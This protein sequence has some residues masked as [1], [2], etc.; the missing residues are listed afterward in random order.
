VITASDRTT[1]I[2]MWMANPNDVVLAGDSNAAEF[3]FTDYTLA[4]G[5]VLQMAN[6]GLQGN[7]AAGVAS[8]LPQFLAEMASPPKVLIY[9]CPVTNDRLIAERPYPVSD[10]QWQ[11]AAFTCLNALM[12]QYPDLKLLLETC[13]LPTRAAAGEIDG[14][15]VVSLNTQIRLNMAPQL[16]SA[17]PNRVWLCDTGTFCQ[18]P[19]DPG[20]AY[21]PNM[22]ADGEHAGWGFHT[23][24]RTW[25][26]YYLNQM[27]L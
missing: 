24:R 2:S 6:A 15:A 7:D 12:Q 13:Y 8:F 19:N 3:P 22:L 27:G 4:S 21:A 17:F 18:D 14:P 16:N 9:Y 23:Q 1:L 11:N 10:D 20:W 26:T 5:K 25:H